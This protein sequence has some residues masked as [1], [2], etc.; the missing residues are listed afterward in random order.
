MSP[1]SWGVKLDELVVQLL[2]HGND[3]VGHTL[4]FS[5]PTIS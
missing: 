2:S 3:S 1:L 5:E 4:D